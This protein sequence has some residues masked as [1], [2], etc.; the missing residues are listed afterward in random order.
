MTTMRPNV[1]SV[2]NAAGSTSPETVHQDIDAAFAGEFADLIG[3]DWIGVIDRCIRPDAMRDLPLFGR[4]TA[5]N[6]SC[7]AFPSSIERRDVIPFARFHS[8]SKMATTVS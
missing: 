7:I 1:A 4:V 2:F 8:V 5:P 6:R 3:P